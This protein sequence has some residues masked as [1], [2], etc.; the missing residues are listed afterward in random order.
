MSLA[1]CVF[2]SKY[3]AG[4]FAVLV[5]LSACNEPVEKRSA[6]TLVSDTNEVTQKKLSKRVVSLLDVN[7]VMFKDLNKNAQLDLYE[8][9]RLSAEQRADDLLAKM[10]LKEKAG[11][12]LHGS[13]PGWGDSYEMDKVATMITE[14]FVHTAITRLSGTPEHLARENNKVQALAEKNRLGIPMMISTDPRNHFQFTAGA[15]S[16]ASGFSQWPE[17]LGFASLADET[18]IREFANIARQEYRAVGIHMGLSPQ[19]DLGTEPRWS[20]FNGTFGEDAQLSKKLVQAYIEG[21]QNGNTG[22]SENSVAMV[23]KHWVGYGAAVDGFDSHNYYGRYAQFPGNNF[24]YHITPFEGAFS[25]QVSGV[26]PAYSILKDL[27]LDGKPL[28]QVGAGFNHYLLNDLLRGKYGFDGV[29]LS[30]WAITNDCPL[31]CR[32]GI[33]GEKTQT[34]AEFSTAWGVMELSMTDRFA[35][36]ILAG[37]DQFGGTTELDALVNTVKQGKVTEA[38]LDQSVKRILI[39]K[40]QLGLFED[41]FVNVDHVK[42]LVG[43]AKTQDI[44]SEAQ[45]STL[46]LLENKNAFLPLAKT[47]KKVYLFG[48]TKEAAVSHGLI[49]VDT[50]E[51]ADVAI[52]RAHAPF[53]VLHPNYVFGRM[54]HEGS[55][56][57]NDGNEQYEQIKAASAVVPTIVTVYLDRPAILSNIKDKVQGLFGDFGISDEALLDVVTGRHQPKGKLPFELPASMD[58]VLKQLSDVPYD[59]QEKLYPFAYGLRYQMN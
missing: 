15:S 28:E 14:R 46:V 13:L 8:D 53:E 26:M 30:D 9:W 19:A 35:K 6:E 11:S 49:V 36:G 41:P 48:I 42:A 7:G 59:T 33:D 55:L 1:A 37:L 23:V 20:R 16:S 3:T 5:S 47:I 40:F 29:I 39:Q 52:I 27:V 45:R 44:A 56:A 43:S 34:F 12:M 17:L 2:R 4:V 18:L 25:A 57:F 32:E 21:F 50:P 51:Q 10:T 38:R 54:Q 22:L 24:D 31:V 58:A